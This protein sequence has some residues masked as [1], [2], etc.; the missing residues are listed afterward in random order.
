MGEEVILSRAGKDVVK[1]IPISRDLRT[2]EPG[3]LR[4]LVIPKGFDQTDEE[5]ID[6][7]DRA[8]LV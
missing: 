7:F 5:S 1:I 4:H 8:G 6:E 2:R 3:D